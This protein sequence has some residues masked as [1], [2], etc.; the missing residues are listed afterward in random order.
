VFGAIGVLAGLQLTRRWRPPSTRRG[1]WLPVA[2]ALGLLAALG[3]AGER[4]DVLAHFLGLAFGVL[5]G[6]LTAL[7]AA[8]PLHTPAQ[9]ALGAAAIAIVVHSWRLALA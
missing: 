6:A 5:L 9:L 1:A 4:T 7:A 8:R 2:A 3:T